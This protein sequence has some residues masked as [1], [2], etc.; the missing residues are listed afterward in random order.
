MMLKSAR[1]HATIRSGGGA[2]G[3]SGS[4]TPADRISQL[5]PTDRSML[6]RIATLVIASTLAAPGCTRK[7]ADVPTYQL[8]DGTPPFWTMTPDDVAIVAT[9]YC[10]NGGIELAQREMPSIGHDTLD[11]ERYWSVLYHGLTRIP[12]DHFMLLINDATGVIEYVPGE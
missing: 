12:G 5:Y 9:R 8:V 3:S 6:T 1:N 7:E 2:F 10:E 4:S 11:G